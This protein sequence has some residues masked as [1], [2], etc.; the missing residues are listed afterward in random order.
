M[1]IKLKQMTMEQFTDWV[2]NNCY[3]TWLECKDCIFDKVD[4]GFSKSSWINHKDEQTSE[5]LNQE[6]EIDG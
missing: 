4:C 6:I 3:W 1:K 5:F 2:E